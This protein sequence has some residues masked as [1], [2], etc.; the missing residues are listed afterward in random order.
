MVKTY[1][2]SFGNFTNC[3]HWRMGLNKHQLFERFNRDRLIEVTSLILVRQQTF[4]I[5]NH[6]Y[7]HLYF[8]HQNRVN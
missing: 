1:S 2:N 8:Q 7:I 6:Q 4:W 5:Y 3:T